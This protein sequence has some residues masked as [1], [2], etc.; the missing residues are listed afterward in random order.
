MTKQLVTLDMSQLEILQPRAQNLASA[1]GTPA[2]GQ[3]WFNTTTNRIEF[4]AASGNIDPSARANHTGTQTV[5]TLSDYTTAT[6]GLITATRLDQLTA[7][8]TGL[9]LATQKLINLANG[10]AATDAVNFGQ[11]QAAIN[12]FDWK[13]SCRLATTGNITLSGLTAIDGVT[14]LAN[15][16]ILVRAQ[17]S[18]LTNGIYVASAGAWARATDSAAGTLTSGASVFITEGTVNGNTQWQLT[19][20]DPIVIDTTALVWTNFA[21]GLTYVGDGATINV[22]GTTISANISSVVRK[23]AAN[24]GD[25]SA[26]TYAITHNLNTLD[27]TVGVYATSG[28]LEMGC[29]VTHTSVNV[30]TLDFAVAPALNSLRVVIHG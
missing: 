11:L 23:Y 9:S 1:P 22:V 30:V 3:F 16:R 4:K 7:P 24:V 27:V 25:N 12:G 15:D 6:N 29:N 21:A 18:A 20:D 10:T 28:G 2:L 14:P 17:S 19:T 13:A 8:N 26:L 5:S